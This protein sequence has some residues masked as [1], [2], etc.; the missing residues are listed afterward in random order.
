MHCVAIG[1]QPENRQRRGRS[2]GS[3]CRR[4]PPVVPKSSATYTSPAC[5]RSWALTP[6]RLLGPTTCTSTI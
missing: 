3:G 6:P 1:P 5:R 4:G 2:G